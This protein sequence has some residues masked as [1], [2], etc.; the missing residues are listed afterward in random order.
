MPLYLTKK[1][2]SS[3]SSFSFRENQRLYNFLGILKINGHSFTVAV[4]KENLCEKVW[5][6]QRIVRSVLVFT[7]GE[8]EVSKHGASEKIYEGVERSQRRREKSQSYYELV[9]VDVDWEA[10]PNQWYEHN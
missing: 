7:Q 5:G 3:L 9:P 10:H 8:I 6:Y 1:F 2:P 4:G